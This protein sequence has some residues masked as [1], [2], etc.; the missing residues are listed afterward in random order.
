MTTARRRLLC[1]VVLCAFLPLGAFSTLAAA[2]QCATMMVASSD[3][4]C[5]PAGSHPP[6]MCPLHQRES[7]AQCRFSCAA[8]GQTLLLL[9]VARPESPTGHQV[10]A[11][12]P[13]DVSPSIDAAP[14]ARAAS[15]DAPPPR[16]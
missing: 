8:G 7:T 12:T 4:D 10:P 11:A 14:L 1:A 2:C 6:G 5:C 13:A 16:I 9:T 3:D 15:P